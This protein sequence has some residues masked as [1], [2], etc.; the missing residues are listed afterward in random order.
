MEN[1]TQISGFLTPKEQEDRFHKALE[2][3]RQFKD[4]KSLDEIWFRVYEA[5][6]ANASNIC[7]GICN[8]TFHD[9]LMD[10]VETVMRYI[11]AEGK[12]PVSLITYCYLPTFGKFCG[13]KQRREDNE[14]SYEFYNEQGYQA[15][16]NEVGETIEDYG[17]KPKEKVRGIC[18]KELMNTDD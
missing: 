13:L 14:G 12:D 10:A 1:D 17:I 9:R 15:A 18:N 2:H 3:Y 5:C 4:K 16:V 8:S 11:V 6:K 7:K